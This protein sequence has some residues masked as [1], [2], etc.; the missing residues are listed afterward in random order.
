MIIIYR[1]PKMGFQG[2][3]EVFPSGEKGIVEQVFVLAQCV[4]GEEEGDH[5]QACWGLDVVEWKV[6]I[7]LKNPV[8]WVCAIKGRKG[9]F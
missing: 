2:S 6:L 5:V 3:V 4:F 8:K 9:D 7:C 1:G